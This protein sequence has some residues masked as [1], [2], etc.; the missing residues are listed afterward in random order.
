MVVDGCCWLVG[1]WLLVVVDGWLLLMVGWLFL[2]T[3][4]WSETPEQ[5]RMTHLRRHTSKTEIKQQSSTQRQ[6]QD[7]CTKQDPLRFPPQPNAQRSRE[8]SQSRSTNAQGGTSQPQTKQPMT[9]ADN[10]IVTMPIGQW[11]STQ[12]HRRS[13]YPAERT[14]SHAVQ[15]TPGSIAMSMRQW[16]EPYTPQ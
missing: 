7:P 4:N 5:V 12:G 13:D 3:T 9:T 16:N 15:K 8:N 14:L 1:C 10:N 11:S 6:G 2:G